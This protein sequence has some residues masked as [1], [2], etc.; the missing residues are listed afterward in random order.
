MTV[1]IEEEYYFHLE[2][3]LKFIIQ[4]FKRVVMSKTVKF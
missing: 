4:R 1:Y 2:K 3:I